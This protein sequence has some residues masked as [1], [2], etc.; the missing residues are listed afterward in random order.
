M[1]CFPQETPDPIWNQT[2]QILQFP[3]TDTTTSTADV[4]CDGNAATCNT[5]S[6]K[7]VN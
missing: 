1:K 6:V 4:V 3:V 5:Q 7:F 2:P